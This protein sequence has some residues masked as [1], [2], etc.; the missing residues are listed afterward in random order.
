MKRRQSEQSL[1]RAVAQYLDAALPKSMFWTTF[2]AGGGGRIRGAQLKAMGLRAGVPDL[3]IMWNAATLGILQVGWIELKAKRGM[4]SMVQDIVHH[5]L[6]RMGCHVACCRSLD[7][8]QETLIGWG[9]VPKATV[10]R[11]AA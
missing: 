9:I 4:V 10:S 1:H 11:R 8:V 2:P 3:L 7:D 5:D 6:R